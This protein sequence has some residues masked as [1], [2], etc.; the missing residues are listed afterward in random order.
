MQSSGRLVAGQRPP[1]D[2]LDQE[3]LAGQCIA[4]I[5]ASATGARGVAES[6]RALG[7]VVAKPVKRTMSEAA[8]AKIS[9]AAKARWV[10]IKAASK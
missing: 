10:K 4:G 6:K 8:K 9:A 7:E 5:S 1:D 2:T 3:G